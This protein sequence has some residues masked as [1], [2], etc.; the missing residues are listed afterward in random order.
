MRSAIFFIFLFTSV[1]LNGQEKGSIQGE[2]LDKKNNEPLAF[3]SV[4]VKNQQNEIILGTITDEKGKFRFQNLVANTYV[5][6]IEFIG[7]IKLRETVE[8]KPKQ[9]VELPAFHLTE[10]AE[11]LEEVVITAEKSTIEQRIDRKVVNVGKDLISQGPAAIDLMN[12]LPSVNVNSDGNISFR[13]SSNVRIL[14]D[15]K[16]SNLENPDEVLQQIPS[17]SIKR[18]ELI[19]NPSAKYNPDG[20]N[21]IINI[22]LKKKS[23]DGW[24]VALNTN[25]IF[26]QEQR[27][28]NRLS[29][30]L[31]PGKSNFYLEYNNSFG[32]QITDGFLNRFD[33]NSSQITRNVNNRRSNVIKLGADFYPSKNSILS[34]LTNQ[35]L[36]KASF[37]G[38]KNIVFHD[39]TGDSDFSLDDLL[40]RDNHTQVYNIDYKWLI[41]GETHFLELEVNSNLFYSDIINKFEFMGSQNCFS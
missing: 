17:N 9:I 6:E 31:K 11:L 28:S 2:I 21:G 38:L 15:G 7:F 10:D 23:Q 14:I 16:L 24:N 13:G 34:I 36:Y 35:N 27:Y 4:I 8:V 25:A 18:I 1:L 40:E 41:D 12:N 30:N 37:D 26:A 32:D 33:L 20:L 22:V 39:T 5:L 29:L 3:A 19:S